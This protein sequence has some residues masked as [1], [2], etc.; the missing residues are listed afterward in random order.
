MEV[1][2]E[3][4]DA[5]VCSGDRAGGPEAAAKNCALRRI[6]GG[7]LL[8]GEATFSNGCDHAHWLTNE[9]IVEDDHEPMQ[10]LVPMSEGEI[11]DNWHVF[12]LA[13]TGS[14]VVP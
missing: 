2:G 4:P 13:G 8:N 11:I 6:D 12:K 7:F 10:V 14:K 1:W 3:N 5:L 9:S